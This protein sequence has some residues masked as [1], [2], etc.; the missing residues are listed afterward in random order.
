MIFRSSSKGLL[1]LEGAPLAG[2][3]RVDLTIRPATA[4][5][6]AAK[7]V[8]MVIDFGNSRTGALLNRDRSGSRR[9]PAD[10]TV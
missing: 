5:A 2:L 10:G 8:H 3:P 4:G 7:E 9:H 1:G 6:G